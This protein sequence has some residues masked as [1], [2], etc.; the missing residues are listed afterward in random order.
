[1]RDWWEIELPN[2]APAGLIVE[3]ITQREDAR[4]R[5]KN[6]ASSCIVMLVQNQKEREFGLNQIKEQKGVVKY[7]C[8]RAVG[9]T[10]IAKDLKEI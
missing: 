7:S 2:Q 6:A 4:V 8:G 9:S 5:P 10:D 1:M 3:S